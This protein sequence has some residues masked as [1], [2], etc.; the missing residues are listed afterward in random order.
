MLR[1]LLNKYYERQIKDLEVSLLK[2]PNNIKTLN[3]LALCYER[4]KNY[5]RAEQLIGMSLRA[6]PANLDTRK[7]A[8]LIDRNKSREIDLCKRLEDESFKRKNYIHKIIQG[9]MFHGFVLF[10]ILSLI[11]KGWFIL[12]ACLF[13]ILKIINAIIWDKAVNYKM[14][15]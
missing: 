5:S 11:F 7:I 12:F 3:Y 4:E 13:F 10:V 8:K 14:G 2:N 15:A 1:R 9:T 6:N